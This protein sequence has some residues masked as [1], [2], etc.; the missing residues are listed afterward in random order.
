MK[1]LNA[2]T[3]S[4]EKPS[5]GLCEIEQLL[6]EIDTDFSGALSTHLIK[7]S[8]VRTGECTMISNLNP[9][10]LTFEG[11]VHLKCVTLN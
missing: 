3:L 8:V 7:M 2:Q 1:K 10:V 6:S 11:T 4:S 5:C 9:I